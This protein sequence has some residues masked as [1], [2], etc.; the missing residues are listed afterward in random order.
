MREMSAKA[1]CVTEYRWGKMPRGL[2]Q[3]LLSILRRE[4]I[5]NRCV[6]NVQ[7]SLRAVGVPELADDLEEEIEAQITEADTSWRKAQRDWPNG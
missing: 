3:A 4:R 1:V 7:S 6:C 2:R 5:V